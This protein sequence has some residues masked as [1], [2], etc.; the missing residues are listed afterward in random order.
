MIN[1]KNIFVTGSNG[2]IGQSLCHILK[3]KYNIFKGVQKKVLSQQP[4]QTIIQ[5]LTSV[6]DWDESFKNIDTII[7][8]AARVHILR[9]DSSDPLQ[10]FR[11]VNTYGTQ[12]LAYA[13]AKQGVRRFIFVSSIGVNGSKTEGLPFSESDTPNPYNA[14][15]RSK[16]EAEALLKEVAR[17]TGLEVVILRPPLVY[18]PGVKGNFLTLLNIVAKGL[19]LPFAAINNRRSYLSV[20]NLIDCIDHV[21]DHPRAQGEIFCICDKEEI[22]TSSLIEKL[23]E[24]MSKKVWQPAMPSS[25]LYYFSRI[26]GMNERMGKLC[27]SLQIDASKAREVL[28]WSPPFSMDQGLKKTVSWYMENKGE[29]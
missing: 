23:A 12:N 16:L 4:Y 19:P 28:Q 6:T 5:D 10:A 27:T 21:I 2:F 26:F 11:A 7:H 17:E 9:E 18:G 20:Y 29:K 15:C 24:Y 3:Q 22:S 8:L 13:A 14:Y 1:R 25:V